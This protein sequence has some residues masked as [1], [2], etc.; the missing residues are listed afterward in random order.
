MQLAAVD[1]VN[2]SL[3]WVRDHLGSFHPQRPQVISGEI[4]VR[5]ARDGAATG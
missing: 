1:A 2:R 3:A 4:K 5:A